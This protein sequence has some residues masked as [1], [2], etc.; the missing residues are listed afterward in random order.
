MATPVSFAPLAG[1]LAARAA[2]I[3]PTD[4][5]EASWANFMALFWCAIYQMLIALCEAL[6]ARA[7]ADA[8][9]LLAASASRDVEAGS[10]QAIRAERQAPSGETRARRLTLVP[11]VQVTT[12]KPDYASSRTTE[13]PTPAAPWLAW[14]REPGSIRAVLAP[15]WRSCRE[16]RAFVPIIEHIYI[17]TMS[18]LLHLTIILAYLSDCH[19]NP[20]KE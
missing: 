12:P 17:V 19:T 8:A 13:R 20:H 2:E 9:R 14:S 15:P 6:D 18:Y 7:A 4:G 11:Q 10:V 5:A 3:R 16:T 1:R